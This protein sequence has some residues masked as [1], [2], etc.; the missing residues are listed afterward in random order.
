MTQQIFACAKLLWTSYGFA[1]GK[2]RGNWCNG[3][4]D[5]LLRVS[6]QLVTDLIRGNWC[7][8]FWPLGL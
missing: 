5:N 2:L 6:H 4:W 1:A 8:G 3:F 7:N